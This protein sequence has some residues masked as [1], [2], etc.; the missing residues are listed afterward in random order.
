MDRKQFL[1]M[2]GLAC[3]APLV[4]SVASATPKPQRTFKGAGSR[5][6]D[7][8]TR[9]REIEERFHPRQVAFFHQDEKRGTIIGF[10]DGQLG[11]L[12]IPPK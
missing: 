9:L 12:A 1:K 7:Y 5:Y 8:K 3:L 2:I 6:V 11:G 10:A 4:A